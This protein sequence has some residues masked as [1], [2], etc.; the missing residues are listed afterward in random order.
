MAQLATQYT[1]IGKVEYFR[2][3]VSAYGIALDEVGKY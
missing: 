3:G 1:P 2:E